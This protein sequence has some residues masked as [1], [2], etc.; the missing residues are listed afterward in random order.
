ML[1]QIDGRKFVLNVGGFAEKDVD[2]CEYLE[3]TDGTFNSV[4]KD[5]PEIPEEL[6]LSKLITDP[7]TGE[8]ILIGGQ[9]NF[10]YFSKNM[11]KIEF[12][13]GTWEKIGELDESRYSHVSFFINDSDFEC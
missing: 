7:V 4:W 10:T 11:Y 1:H 8:A 5:C 2:F 3:V 6:S 13:N 9:R 12:I